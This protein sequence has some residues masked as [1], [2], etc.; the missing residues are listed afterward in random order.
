MMAGSS[1][2]EMY[3]NP[4]SASSCFAWRRASSKASPCMMTFAPSSRH[5]LTF[6]SGAHLGITTVTGMPRSPPWYATPSAWFPAD[7]AI[8]PRRRS[9]GDSSSSLLRA[10]R[11]LNEPVIWRWSSFE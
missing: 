11:S 8:T 10:P 4:R 1:K 2:P 3:V 9:S 7:A 6:T 5:F